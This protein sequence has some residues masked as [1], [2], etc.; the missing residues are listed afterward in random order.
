MPSTFECLLHLSNATGEMLRGRP[1]ASPVFLGA[2]KICEVMFD[3]SE[4]ERSDAAARTEQ[5]V[6]PLTWPGDGEAS[7]GLLELRV[8]P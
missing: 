8:V 5:G 4:H 1:A 6:S 3:L 2:E 7:N